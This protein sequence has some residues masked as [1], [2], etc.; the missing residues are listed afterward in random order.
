MCQEGYTNPQKKKRK[1]GY[2]IVWIKSRYLCDKKKRKK[3]RGT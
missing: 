1:E 2:T 3:K